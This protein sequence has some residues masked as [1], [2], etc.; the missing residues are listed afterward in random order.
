MFIYFVAFVLGTLVSAI[1]LWGGMQIT[2]VE[3]TFTAM[4]TIAAICTGLSFIPMA[5]GLISLVAMC[6]LISMMTDA[7]FWPDTVLMVI[8]T[9]I[10]TAA[11]W[12]MLTSML[13]AG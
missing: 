11:M 7:N 9:K 13:T 10:L 12:A 3:G 1:C 2:K 6:V 4:L 8:V 5:G